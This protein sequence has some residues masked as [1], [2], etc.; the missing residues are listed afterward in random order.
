MG[1]TETL[2]EL[3][4]LIA[5]ASRRRERAVCETWLG[6]GRRAFCSSDCKNTYRRRRRAAQKRAE[7][8]RQEG[9][10]A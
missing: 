1:E 5:W 4:R 9:A 10:R 6:Q 7:S 3:H 8:E 2:D